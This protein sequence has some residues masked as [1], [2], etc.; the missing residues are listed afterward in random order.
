MNYRVDGL[1]P[2]SVSS[3]VDE[4]G[5]RLLTIGREK[6]CTFTLDTAGQYVTE[7]MSAEAVPILDAAPVHNQELAVKAAAR[8]AKHF[9]GHGPLLSVQRTRDVTAGEDW[10]GVKFKLRPINGVRV[11][12]G[13][14]GVTLSSKSGKVI[15]FAYQK[16]A[17]PSGPHQQRLSLK[18]AQRVASRLIRTGF[19]GRKV[20]IRF[21]DCELFILTAA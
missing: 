10:W 17:A 5:R 11:G 8:V 20:R 4:A 7:F 9:D 14:A 19:P 13:G 12:F 21:G 3:R 6:E 1:A 18:A 15:C 2:V 16:V